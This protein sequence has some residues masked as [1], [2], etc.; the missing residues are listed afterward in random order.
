MYP[1][2]NAIYLKYFKFRKIFSTPNGNR[3]CCGL[4]CC[5]RVFVAT[6]AATVA[7]V[8][9][10]VRQASRVALHFP[11]R[12]V[13]SGSHFCCCFKSLWYLCS[14]A[15]ETEQCVAAESKICRCIDKMSNATANQTNSNSSNSNHNNCSSNKRQGN[16]NTNICRNR[17]S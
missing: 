16:L 3:C 4:C 9:V 13:E 2:E 1:N 7:A 12:E 17:V 10:A 5:C 8:I 11:D 15:C 6:A 14:F